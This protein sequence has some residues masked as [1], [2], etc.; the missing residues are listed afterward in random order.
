MV[1]FPWSIC[2]DGYIK[3]ST[4]QFRSSAANLEH[5]MANNGRQS[6]SI[7]R[8]NRSKTFRLRKGNQKKPPRLS[9]YL[10]KENSVLP[11]LADKDDKKDYQPQQFSSTAN[12]KPRR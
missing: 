9:G 8:K 12:C 3:G 1:R 2:Q 5:K 11:H 10:E 6:R 7:E 4:L